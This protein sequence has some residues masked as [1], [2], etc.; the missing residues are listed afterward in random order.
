VKR[1]EKGNI[2]RKKGPG[3]RKRKI[4]TAP[5][6]ATERTVSTREQQK[7]ADRDQQSIG[8][9]SHRTSEL[10]RVA[11]TQRSLGE[12]QPSKTKPEEGGG[13]PESKTNLKD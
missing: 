6:T 3:K 10:S 5:D 8:Q 2:K 9:I 12:R 1:K 7:S 4:D 11:T 13:E